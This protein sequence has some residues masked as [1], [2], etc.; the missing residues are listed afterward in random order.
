MNE[1]AV[2]VEAFCARARGV[3]E[4]KEPEEVG[5]VMRLHALGWGSR[6]IARELGISRTTVMRYLAQGAWVR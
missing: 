3:E 1:R 4:M 2:T 6:R 5:V